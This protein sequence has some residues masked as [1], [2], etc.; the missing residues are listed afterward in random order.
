MDRKEYYEVSRWRDYWR[1]CWNT[2]SRGFSQA[3]ILVCWSSAGAMVRN[4]SEM[5]QPRVRV[6]RR[7]ELRAALSWNCEESLR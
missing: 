1:R 4:S 2:A 5:R 3:A 7:Y 6:T